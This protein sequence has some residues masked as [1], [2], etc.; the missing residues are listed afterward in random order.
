MLVHFTE[1][2]DFKPNQGKTDILGL[3]FLKPLTDRGTWNLWYAVNISGQRPRVYISMTAN[4]V[5]ATG[6]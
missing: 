5:L 6:S 4:A 3:K 2:R 1:I